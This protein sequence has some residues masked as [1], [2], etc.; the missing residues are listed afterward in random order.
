[1]RLILDALYLVMGLTYLPFLIYQMVFLKKNRRGWRQRFGGVPRRTDRRPAIWIHAVSLGEVNATRQM[2]AALEERLPQFETV[3]SVTTDTGHAAARRLYPGRTVFRY[4]LDFS[5]VVARALRRIRPAAIVLM[6]LEVWPNLIA[7]AA[8]RGIPVCIANGR[9]TEERSMRRFRRTPLRGMAR[10]MF[11]RIGWVGAQSVAYAERFVELGAPRDR[12]AVTGSMKFD[13][14]DVCDRVDGDADL[15]AAMGIDR[16]RPLIVAGSTGP[17]EEAP[18]LESY[19]KILD[20]HGNAQ[21]AIIP[22]KPERFE[23]VARTIEAAGFSCRRRSRHPDGAPTSPPGTPRTL[24]LGDTMGELRKFYSLASVVFVGR[25]LVPLGGSD[26]MEIAALARPM[27]FGPHVENFADIAGELL[28]ENA[29]VQI[30]DVA[31]LD[32]AIGSLLADNQRATDIGRRARQVVEKN[33]G[34][35]QQTVEAIVHLLGAS[36]AS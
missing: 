32:A 22:R 4:P 13:T 6:E 36:A 20:T 31:E 35:T 28:R 25:T 23:E 8:A 24:F 33:R 9:V 10:R 7:M 2:V 21:L 30:A 27:C 16:S 29:A 11:S 26:L 5:F 19:R 3:L 12:V 1:M 34:A 15:A 17:G 18:L 14:A